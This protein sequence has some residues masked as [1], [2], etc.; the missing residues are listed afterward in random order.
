MR[1]AEHFA[2]ECD[3]VPALVEG[4]R[5]D[6]VAGGR[7]ASSSAFRV[8]PCGRRSRWARRAARRGSRRIRSR[9]SRCRADRRGD[10]VGRLGVRRGG[11]R[12]PTWLDGSSPGRLPGPI[13]AANT[14]TAAA[15]TAA[16]SVGD[17]TRLPISMVGFSSGTSAVTISHPQPG[18]R[19]A[20]RNA[21]FPRRHI[22]C[23]ARSSSLP[24]MPAHTGGY[25][26]V[27]TSFSR[28]E[29]TFGAEPEGQV[30][31]QPSGYSQGTL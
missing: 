23:R 14:T 13:S 19:V 8:R 31:C 28:N 20:I 6:R 24:G 30:G 27:W 9:R 3:A 5:I 4:V 10:G 29:T 26:P 21:R 11:I 2:F 1:V 18:Q 15:A 22:A 25:H 12:R 16:I 17:R 7:P